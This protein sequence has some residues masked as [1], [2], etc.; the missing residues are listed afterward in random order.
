MTNVRAKKHL[1]QHFLIELSVAEKIVGSVPENGPKTILEIGPGMGVLTQF[2]LKKTDLTT[3]V[4]EIDSESVNYLKINY[5]KLEPRIIEGDFLKINLK[6][7]FS[8]SYAIIG[9]F[10]YNISSQILFRVIEHRDQIPIVVGMFQKEVAKRIAEGPGTKV[11]GILSVLLQAYYDIEYLFTVN[12]GAFNPPP[13]VKS[14]VIRLVRNNTDKLA[15][16]EKLFFKVVKAGFNQRRKTLT[17]SLKGLLGG[18]KINDE[19]FRK[20]PEQL[21]VAE[22]V[23]LTNLVEEFNKNNGVKELE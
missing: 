14:G 4:I 17:N 12:E 7:Y 15:C 22:F 5:P 10:P 18:E 11:Y 6:D 23:K 19:I 13:K 16:D 9:N 21:S 20:R 3:H 2:L 8:E 1:G